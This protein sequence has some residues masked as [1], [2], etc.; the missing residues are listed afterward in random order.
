MDSKLKTDWA[1][2][3]YHLQTLQIWWKCLK[4]LGNLQDCAEYFQIQIEERSRLL[5]SALRGG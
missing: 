1:I 2:V 4:G 3:V 5:D